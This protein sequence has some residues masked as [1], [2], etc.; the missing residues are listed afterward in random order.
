MLTAKH[1][2]LIHLARRQ[3]D[4]DDE[5][6]RAILCLHGGGVVSS[7]DLDQEGFEGVM[8]HFTACGFRSDWTKRT[9]GNRPGMASPAQIDLILLLW[10]EWSGSDD[11]PSLNKWLE[12]SYHVAALRFVTPDVAGKAINGLRAMVAR[13]TAESGNVQSS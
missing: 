4:F 13:K 10:K 11:D 3:L 5:I 7:K 2:R 6:Y 1:I 12:R 9:F 8:A